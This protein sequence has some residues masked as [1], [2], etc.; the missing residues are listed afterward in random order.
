MRLPPSYAEVGRAVLPLRGSAKAAEPR[1]ADFVR[2]V[3][4]VLS[5]SLLF[6]CSESGTDGL[7][8]DATP[9]PVTDAAIVDASAPPD[10]GTAADVSA[11]DA[12]ADAGLTE[13]PDAGPPP[14]DRE[15]Y[16]GRALTELRFSDDGSRLFF[17]DVTNTNAGT[18]VL[19]VVDVASGAVQRLDGDVHA[20]LGIRPS[21]DGRHVAYVQVTPTGRQVVWRGAGRLP[22]VLIPPGANVDL[23][24]VWAR[25]DGAGLVWLVGTTLWML[26]FV[27]GQPFAIVQ[28]AGNDLK[29]VGGFG[30][31][32][33]QGVG[34]VVRIDFATRTVTPVGVPLVAGRRLMDGMAP[35]PIAIYP[36][37]EPDGT[38][39]FDVIDVVAGTV[40]RTPTGAGVQVSGSGRF[41]LTVEQ[42]GG[43]IDVVDLERGVV[44][45]TLASGHAPVAFVLGERG[46]LATRGDPAGMGELVVASTS[47]S[48]VRV[49]GSPPY[50]A[51]LREILTVSPSGA[52]LRY[53]PDATQGAVVD[54]ETGS[55]RTIACGSYCSTF[56][57]VDDGRGGMWVDERLL[58]VIDAASG[59][60]QT[61][62]E[63][64]WIARSPDDRHALLLSDDATQALALRWLGG[65]SR[66]PEVGGVV[67]AY[68]TAA[69]DTHA[70]MVVERAAAQVVVIS[71]WP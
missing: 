39:A 10:A 35:G 13:P 40:R 3:V 5:T 60:E 68:L 31:V 46:L 28:G 53:Q 2:A 47:S 59:V 52:R 26:D 7:T 45:Q 12:T 9:A 20:M 43:P 23:R 24:S 42:R 25:P 33:G 51:P 58:H 57:L 8:G 69:S 1:Y 67:S 30:V 19:S 34:E 61:Y 38:G 64:R 55:A 50:T 29:L 15:V 56:D 18:G 27:D 71:R 6:A 48:A 62:G 17:V 65:A 49:V 22:E 66:R 44:V 21:P 37:Y 63:R 70:A 54:L 4:V 32:S 11:P 36:R 16:S 14:L 41:A